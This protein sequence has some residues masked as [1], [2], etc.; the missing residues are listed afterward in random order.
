MHDSHKALVFRIKDDSL[1]LLYILLGVQLRIPCLYCLHTFYSPWLNSRIP[2]L[3]SSGCN[4]H[5]SHTIRFFRIKDGSLELFYILP[6]LHLIKLKD[7]SLE[8]L[9]ILLGFT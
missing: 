8:L 6:D 9:Y 7:G 3:Y 2:C 5:N 1:E 4:L